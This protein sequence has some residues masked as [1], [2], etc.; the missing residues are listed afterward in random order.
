VKRHLPHFTETHVQTI[1]E[2]VKKK[3]LGIVF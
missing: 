3:S 2:Q 1:R